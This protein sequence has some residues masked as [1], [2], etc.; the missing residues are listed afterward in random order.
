M[1]PANPQ[2]NTYSRHKPFFV[3]LFVGAFG[4]G[5]AL[6]FARPLAIEIAAILF[7]L[8]YLGLVAFRLPKLTAQHLKAHADSD[9]LLRQWPSS[10]LR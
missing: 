4:L 3:A 8:T 2:S 9:D 1:T 10:P 7:F 5:L 6:A